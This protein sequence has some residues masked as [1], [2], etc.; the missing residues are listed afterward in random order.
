M[1]GLE[2]AK[3]WARPF[4]EG[5][6]IFVTGGTSGIGRAIAA[7]F[8]DNGASV[9]ATGAT[10]KEVE[11]AEAWAKSAGYQDALTFI[12]LDVRDGAAIDQAIGSLPTLYGLVNCAGIIRRNEELDPEVFAQVIDINL[13]GTLRAAHAAK[14]LLAKSGGSI[15]NT[16]SM[17]SFFGGG[18]VPAYSASKGGIM[19]LTKSLAI[20]WAK[21]GIRVNAIAPG[22]IRTPL[23]ANL[24][25]DPERTKAI[26]SRTPMGR[27]GEPDDLA[28]P[29]V[30]LST[31]LAG[32][33]TGAILPV[34]GGYLTA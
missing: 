32:F 28:H 29:A 20:A 8:A 30:F 5:Q 34:D 13:N 31:P 25:D 3:D 2:K 6:S 17:L 1:S 15:V 24:Q 33:I 16:A 10:A 12:T 7:S 18:V 23:T 26:L 21:D 11:Q 19:Q 22:W 14:P 27:W 9:T 4:L